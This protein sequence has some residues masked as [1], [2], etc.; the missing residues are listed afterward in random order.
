M[1]WKI[2]AFLHVWGFLICE[3]PLSY[4]WEKVQIPVGAFLLYRGSCSCL[5][6]KANLITPHQ[7]IQGLNIVL[8]HLASICLFNVYYLRFVFHEVILRDKDKM[9]LNVKEETIGKEIF[10]IHRTF[11]FIIYSLI[12]WYLGFT[13][14]SIMIL[15]CVCLLE[16]RYRVNMERIDSRD[17]GVW[18]LS[19][20]LASPLVMW[21]WNII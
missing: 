2:I 10:K 4:W 6:R 12:L 21:S 15:R 17:P 20:I 18:L 19:S 3:L 7:F 13:F 1:L 8:C 5:W 14:N 9:T 16:A 11:A